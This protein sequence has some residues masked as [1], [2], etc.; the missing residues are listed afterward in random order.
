[1][2]H[3]TQGKKKVNTV[4]IGRKNGW[5]TSILSDPTD[6]IVEAG[7]ESHEECF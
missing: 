2:I 3:I 6:G 4:V 1:M 7:K 5:K